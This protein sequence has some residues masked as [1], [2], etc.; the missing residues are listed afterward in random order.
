LR[1]CGNCL[2][3]PRPN[4]RPLPG[5]KGSL[6]TSNRT[7]KGTALDINDDKPEFEVTAGETFK[8]VVTNTGKPDAASYIEG[9]SEAGTRTTLER[10]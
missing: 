8:F 3:L 7:N 9:H 6:T 1:S 2:S 4:I 5:L 10:S